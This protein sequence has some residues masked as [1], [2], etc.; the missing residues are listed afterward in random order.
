M[1]N[2]FNDVCKRLSDRKLCQHPTDLL[3]M[4]QLIEHIHNEHAAEEDPAS[5]D[6]DDMPGLVDAQGLAFELDGTH[7]HGGG[8]L[9]P[10]ELEPITL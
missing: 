8:H 3:E 7:L 2:R 6:Y 5:E 4:I 1:I 9:V 10:T